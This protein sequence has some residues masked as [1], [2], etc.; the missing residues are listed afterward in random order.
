M[1]L[2]TVILPACTH[3]TLSRFEEVSTMLVENRVF[4]LCSMSYAP[5]FFR[6]RWISGSMVISKR[7]A[8]SFCPLIH[9]ALQELREKLAVQHEL[10]QEQQGLYALD[11]STYHQLI[12]QYEVVVDKVGS[13]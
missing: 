9:A 11:S 2:Q 6:F 3:E 12:A 4:S 8:I 5:R 10:E 7:P 13:S 1:S